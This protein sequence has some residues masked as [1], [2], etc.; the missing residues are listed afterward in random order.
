[1]KIKIYKDYIL[2]L[3]KTPDMWIHVL[4]NRDITHNHGYLF[5]VLL[6]IVKFLR[7]NQDTIA[8]VEANR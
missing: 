7:S 8:L 6:T 1:M 2:D 4:L 5:Y 3:Y